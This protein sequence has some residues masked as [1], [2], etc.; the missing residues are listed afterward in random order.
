MSPSERFSENKLLLHPGLYTSVESKS[1]SLK[2]Y[3]KLG[4]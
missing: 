3:S 2:S 1:P 4:K